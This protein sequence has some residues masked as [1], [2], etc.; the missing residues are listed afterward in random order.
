MTREDMGRRVWEH[1]VPMMRLAVSMLISLQDAEDAV[2]ESIVRAMGGA[3]SLRNEQRLKPWLLS[4]VAHCCHDQLRRKKR[5]R[6]TDD[7]AVFDRP[8]FEPLAEDSLMAKL[9]ALD[10]KLSQ[11]LALYYY[12][13]Y[14]TREIAQILGVSLSTVIMRLKRGR[15]KL[16]A[17]YEAEGRCAQ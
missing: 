15:A 5:E 1:R 11:V 17:L 16:K 8:V 6:P 3:E 9:R 13:G 14:L 2:S 7:M 12:E 10:P 4:I